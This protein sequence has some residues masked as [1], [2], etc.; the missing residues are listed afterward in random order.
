MLNLSIRRFEFDIDQCR[1][2]DEQIMDILSYNRIIQ[3]VGNDW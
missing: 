3:S 2:H 1:I